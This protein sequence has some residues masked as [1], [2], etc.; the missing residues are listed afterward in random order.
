MI[1][2]NNKAESTAD[3]RTSER[4]N[5][6]EQQQQN[7]REREKKAACLNYHRIARLSLVCISF[8]FFE[9]IVEIATYHKLK[10]LPYM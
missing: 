5:E 9:V 3:S 2:K 10:K 7:K 4:T 8:F 6:S 1:I